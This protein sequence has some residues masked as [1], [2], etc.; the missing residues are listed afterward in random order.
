LTFQQGDIGVV[1]SRS[2]RVAME[3]ALGKTVF[4]SLNALLVVM[5]KL[6]VHKRRLTTS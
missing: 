5:I 1:V 2:S 4:Q 3:V 6:R